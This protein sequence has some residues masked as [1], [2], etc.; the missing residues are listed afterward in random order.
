M[1]IFVALLIAFGAVQS[2]AAI[3]SIYR[4]GGIL[5]RLRATPLRPA[6]IL[7]THVLVKL[8]FTALTYGLMIL[9]GRRYGLVGTGVPIVSMAL[10]LLVATLSILSMGFVIASVVPT[11]RFAQPISTIVLYPMLGVSGLFF[12]VAAMPPVLRGLAHLLPPTY[13]V[14]LLRGVWYGD[15]WGPHLTDVAALGIL[16]VVFTTIA[17]RMFRWE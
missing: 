15:G 14:S 4:E 2:L 9:A 11:A 6:T 16:F 5:K 12:P 3:M 17:S 1:P 8:T 13:A 7:T 10:A